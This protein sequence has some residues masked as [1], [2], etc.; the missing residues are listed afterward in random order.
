MTH[1]PA[2]SARTRVGLG[3]PAPS[4]ARATHIADLNRRAAR[5]GN[6]LALVS[7]LR[8][9]RRA[10]NRQNFGRIAELRC[11]CAFPTCRETFPAAADYHRGA[12]DRYIV[13]PAHYNGGTPIKVADRF[14]VISNKERL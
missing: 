13:A 7:A 10:E 12:G 9:R 1:A 14:F 8:E 6:P 3:Q 4:A 2:S 11:E 5:G